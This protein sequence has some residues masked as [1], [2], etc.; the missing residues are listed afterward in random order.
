MEKNNFEIKFHVIHTEKGF[1]K[2][3]WTYPYF[4]A[5]V[6]KAA[7]YKTRKGADTAIEKIST[8]G[9]NLKSH[10]WENKALPKIKK[11]VIGT[12]H[13]RPEDIVWEGEDNYFTSF[14]KKYQEQEKAEAKAKFEAILQRRN[15]LD[16]ELE[17]LAGK[18]E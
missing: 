3:E 14:L 16:K 15:E 6:N 1:F 11:A 7:K 13:L 8:F 5:D 2:S 10:M 17:K 18:F 9:R 12:I 4:V